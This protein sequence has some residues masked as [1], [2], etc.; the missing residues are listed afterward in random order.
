MLT[1]QI[2]TLLLANEYVRQQTIIVTNNQYK[3]KVIGTTFLSAIS[4]IYV[5]ASIELRLVGSDFMKVIDLVCGSCNFCCFSLGRI[6]AKIVFAP[7]NQ[8]SN[9]LTKII[10]F[11]GVRWTFYLVVAMEKE[12][13]TTDD[14][15]I[16][17]PNTI[18]NLR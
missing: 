16:S 6:R 17:I 14:D 9:S 13:K 8:L 12:K 4:G 1:D 3:Q 10:K 15:D 7:R 5:I 18:K 2:N 11:V